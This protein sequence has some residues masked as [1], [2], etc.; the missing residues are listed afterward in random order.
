MSGSRPPGAPEG[1]RTMST[2]GIIK[3]MSLGLNGSVFGFVDSDD[4]KLD[5]VYFTAAAVRG[6]IATPGLTVRA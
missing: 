6:F 4:P 2:T 3:R 1:Y 5:S